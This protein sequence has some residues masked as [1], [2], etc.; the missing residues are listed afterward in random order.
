MESFEPFTVTLTDDP[1]ITREVNKHL[2]GADVTHTH[3]D[4]ATGS[5][6]TLPRVMFA[7]FLIAG[8]A[9]AFLADLTN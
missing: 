9:G 4:H 2:H 3:S 5:T 7:L 8:L 1:V 6:M